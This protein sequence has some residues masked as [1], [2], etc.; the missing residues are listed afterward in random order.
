VS[1]DSP[2]DPEELSD[3]ELLKRLATLDEEEYPVARDA[4]RA[5]DQD[6]EVAS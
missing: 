3:E 5:L 6:D 4:Q 2:Q 1:S